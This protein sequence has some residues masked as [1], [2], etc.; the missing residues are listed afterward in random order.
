VV[1]AVVV[2]W[3][4][5]LSI[6]PAAETDGTNDIGIGSGE[7]ISAKSAG[8]GTLPIKSTENLIAIF[9]IIPINQRTT[10]TINEDR[11]LGLVLARARET[12]LFVVASC[13]VVEHKNRK[14]VNK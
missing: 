7:F 9:V 11:L 14:G 8:E 4:F 3:V 10:T 13:F 2:V 1:V 6:S 12:I 5:F